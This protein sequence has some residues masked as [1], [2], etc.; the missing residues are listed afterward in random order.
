MSRVT[1]QR[2]R[3]TIE[4]YL[5]REYDATE[6]HEYYDGDIVAMAGGSPTHS[7][8]ISNVI[9]GLHS[10][11]QGKPCRVYDSNLRVRVPRSNLYVY[12][13][14]TV[15]CG[16]TQ[17]DPADVNRQTV[18]NPTLAVEVLSPSTEHLDYGPKLKQYLESGTLQE[19]IIVTQDAP[20]VQSYFRQGGGTWLFTPVT[21][22]EDVARFRSIEVELPM[23]DIYAGVEFPPPPV[24]P[25]EHLQPKE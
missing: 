21:T 2:P 6:R 9:A 18:T 25:D 3:F 17:H 4:E 14:S 5:R 8:I 13:D 22:F 7:L 15:I 20:H 10:R 1:E 24:P 11:L 23:A 12:P 19:Y 16:P